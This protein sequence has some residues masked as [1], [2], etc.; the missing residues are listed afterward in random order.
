MVCYGITPLALIK[1]LNLFC[2]LSDMFQ[3]WVSSL[4]LLVSQRKAYAIRP[5]LQFIGKNIL[6]YSG[7]PEGVR[8]TF[9][10]TK[11]SQPPFLSCSRR[12]PS[13]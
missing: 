4:A 12:V 7:K 2:V 3:K 10:K 13:C 9:Y 1:S 11:E 8:H 5:T 6:C